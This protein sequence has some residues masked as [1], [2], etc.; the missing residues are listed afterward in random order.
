M[1]WP[2]TNRLILILLFLV[3]I[4]AVGNGANDS[5]SVDKMEAEIK[6]TLSNQPVKA[7]SLAVLYLEQV[8]GN[9]TLE[10]MGWY[11]RAESAYY[12]ADFTVAGDYY[13]KGIDCLSEYN[14]PEKKAILYNNL[15]LTRYYKS[16]YNEALDA[17][18]NSAKF[19]EEAGNMFGFAECL[20]NIALIQ[21]K[22]GDSSK[23]EKYF[24]YARNSFLEMDSLSAAAA[25][26]N[27]YAIFLSDLGQY[28][29]AIEMYHSALDVYTLLKNDEGVAKVK[30]NLGALY[31]Y[32]K[33]Y[34]RSALYL[35]ESLEFFK[36]NNDQSRLINIY[37]L[38][39][40]L[41]F[42]QDRTALSVIFYERAEKIARKMGW[43]DLRQKNLYSL[44][45]ALKEGEEYERA[46]TILETYTL[47]TDSLSLINGQ[48]PAGYRD[49]AVDRVL[50]EKELM[51]ARAKMREKNLLLII[52]GLLL[53]M[54]LAIWFLYGR[55]K[56][57]KHQ[58]EKQLLHQKMMR[59]QMNPHFIFNALASLQNYILSDNK[60]EASDFLS[61]IAF[62]MRKMI[63]YSNVELIALSEEQEVLE[64]YLKV[65]C[66]RYY[67]TIDCGVQ[68][69]VVSDSCNLM[70]PP[71]L[72][73]PLI[74]DFFANGKNRDCCCPGIS[75][76]Y[77]QEDKELEVTIENK[78]VILSD[79]ESE[80]T[81]GIIEDRISSLRKEHGLKPRRMEK[82]DLITKGVV[83]GKRIRYWLPLTGR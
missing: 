36:M 12:R 27:D 69:S 67:Q 11:Y 18:S 76:L 4:V 14:L 47:L 28:K 13:Q 56:M 25:V 34:G 31:L 79:Q 51:L 1:F 57:I 49:D 66:R 42:E 16:R 24:R 62:L 23:A 53:V 68:T 8:S 6:A 52:L 71:M 60:D 37:S 55:N 72:S 83:T 58:K 64:K 38:L 65:Q 15:G 35:D 7:D 9:D 43:D 41:Y 50:T 10:A 45:L 30:C 75:I 22:S 63:G 54:G 40:D 20:Y 19:E 77:K 32:E 73:R 5:L 21:D 78:G 82:V 2:C 17:F 44:F 29:R 33:E 48:Q 61:D 26:S 39:G 59:I 80:A 74:D 3:G 70:V 81:T 46:M